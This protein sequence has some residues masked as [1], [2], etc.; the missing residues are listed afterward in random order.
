MANDFTPGYGGLIALFCKVDTVDRMMILTYISPDSLLT[1]VSGA[2]QE[3]KVRKK[4]K[5]IFWF[6]LVLLFRMHRFLFLT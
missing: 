2:Y 5:N 4:V 1:K 3:P 6:M